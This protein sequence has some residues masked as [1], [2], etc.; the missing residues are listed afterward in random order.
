MVDFLGGNAAKRSR[1][2]K[3]TNDLTQ[4]VV[5]G[6]WNVRNYLAG[7]DKKKAKNANSLSQIALGNGT[8]ETF[9]LNDRLQLAS[10]ELIRGSEV[11]QKY[12]Y[13][14]GEL[15]SQ[16]ALKNNGKLE[17]V[18][19]HIGSAKQ[20]TQKFA[21]DAVGRLSEAAEYRG[22][23]NALSYKQK[24]DFDRFGNMYRKVAKNS[25]TGQ[26][27]PLPFTPVEDTD[28]SKSTNRFTTNTTYS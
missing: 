12:E 11:L 1:P 13:G 16:S 2:E 7:I 4:R 21:Y 3:R 23:T 8:A 22:D 20:W 6:V 26:A 9:A 27:T 25:T 17:S 15:N 24:F 14:Y 19:S 10:Q 28:I 18:T 5:F